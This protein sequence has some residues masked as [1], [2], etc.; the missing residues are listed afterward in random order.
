MALSKLRSLFGSSSRVDLAALSNINK[1][2]VVG[3]LQNWENAEDFLIENG[4]S[5]PAQV[6]YIIDMIPE[7]MA[8]IAF[9]QS[10][11]I[12]PLD[13]VIMVVLGDNQPDIHTSIRSTPL[14]KTIK[15][16]R[17]SDDL[18][19]ETVAELVKQSALADIASQ[20]LNAGDS[21]KGSV[22]ASVF[23]GI[24]HDGEKLILDSE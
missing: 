3:L 4:V 5:N 20:A 13:D 14:Y 17:K 2:I 12:G 8:D 19:S 7:I 9:A 11:E 21:L 1:T 24:K 22:S 10:K 6:R 23:V 16:A 18:P 15:R